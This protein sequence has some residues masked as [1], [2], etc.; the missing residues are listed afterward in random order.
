MV[1][2]SSSS[3]IAR[4]FQFGIVGDREVG[5]IKDFEDLEWA[6]VRP[7]DGYCTVSLTG[8]RDDGAFKIVGK[9]E[10]FA[11]AILVFDED[12]GGPFVGLRSFDMDTVGFSRPYQLAL[13][14]GVKKDAVFSGA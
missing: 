4:S 13:G 14:F 12:I 2:E 10:E 7:G 8:S 3:G 11:M 1:G 5:A 9:S 6:V